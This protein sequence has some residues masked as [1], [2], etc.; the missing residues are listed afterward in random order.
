MQQM[1]TGGVEMIVGLIQDPS[2]GPVVACG[3]GG[4]LA[5]LLHDVSVRLTP[6]SEDDLSEMPRELRTYPL[7]TGYRGTPPCDV[8]ALEDVLRRISALAED[9]PQVAEMDCNP[10]KVLE[11]G[12][13]HRRRQDSGGAGRCTTS[14]RR[15][16]ARRKFHG[17]SCRRGVRRSSSDPSERS[18]VI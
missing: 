14:A 11:H 13:V 12:A 15:A 6:L 18:R 8:T 17:A 10:V 1:V 3:A 4:V 16:R 5:E 7:L 2:F 9:L